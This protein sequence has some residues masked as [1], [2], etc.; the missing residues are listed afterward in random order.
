VF[1][2]VG[3]SIRSAGRGRR[4]G[5]TGP[6]GSQMITAV[7]PSAAVGNGPC[8]VLAERKTKQ[9]PAVYTSEFLSNFVHEPFEHGVPYLAAADRQ[10]YECRQFT[11]TD[12]NYPAADRSAGLAGRN[13]ASRSPYRRYY[14]YYYYC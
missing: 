7:V 4:V 3:V 9:T 13:N 10:P 14:Y 2:T 1:N 6:S 11:D 12:A 5:T 8:R